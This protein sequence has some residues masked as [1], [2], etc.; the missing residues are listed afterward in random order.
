ML[1]ALKRSQTRVTTSKNG[2]SLKILGFSDRFLSRFRDLRTD[3]GGPDRILGG[4]QIDQNLEI[5]DFLES[6]QNVTKWLEMAQNLPKRNGSA[7]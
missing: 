5:F 6:V 4:S 3:F 7:S 1:E 2:F